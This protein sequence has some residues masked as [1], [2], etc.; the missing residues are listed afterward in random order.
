MDAALLIWGK[1]GEFISTYWKIYIHTHRFHPFPAYFCLWPWW[2]GVLWIIIHCSE[3]LRQTAL[4]APC[5]QPPAKPIFTS[6][7]IKKTIPCRWCKRVEQ[8]SMWAVLSQLFCDPE[9]FFKHGTFWNDNTVSLG[10]LAFQEAGRVKVQA[11]L[12]KKNSLP[13][14]AR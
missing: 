14:L 4:L 9:S 11:S 3:H 10:R 12:K 1:P 5:L 6:F 7:L 2:R 13:C 8:T